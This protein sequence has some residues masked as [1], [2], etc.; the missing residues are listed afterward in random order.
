MV[1]RVLSRLNEIIVAEREV[2][3]V[4][5]LALAIYLPAIWWGLPHATH[6]LGVHGWDIDSVTGMQTLSELHNLLI[7]PKQDW[8]VAY[9]LFHYLVV[10]FF[11]GPYFV[12]L[13]LGGGMSQPTAEYPFGFAD[14]VAALKHL[15][16]IG[17][18]ITVLMASGIVVSAYLTA[19][20]VWDE[21]T[22]RFTA[23]AAALPVPMF[24]YAR[25]GNLDVPGLFWASLAI[26]FLTRSSKLGFTA[27]R[28]V[29]L[30]VF[31]SFAVAT[32][33]QAFGPLAVG[34]SML[35]ILHLWKGTPNTEGLPRWKA[36]AALFA[37]G[38]VAFAFA[39]GLVISPYRFFAHLS[40]IRRFEKTFD[41]VQRMDVL[42]PA[43]PY[44]YAVLTLDV[45][46]Q[47]VVALGPILIILGAVGLIIS[48]R[49]GTF[50]KLLVALLCGHLIL[51]IFQIR[52]MQY[53]YIL[54]PAFIFAF[55]IGRAIAVGLGQRRRAVVA[56][57]LATAIAGF[58]WAG[59]RDID[60]TYQMIYDARYEAGEWIAANS[61][62]ADKIGY[63]NA[64]SSIHLYAKTETPFVSTANPEEVKQAQAEERALWLLDD[65][66]PVEKLAGENVRF[67]LAQ[68]DFS[69]E[70]G[71]KRSRFFPES[72]YGQMN[73]GSLGYRKVA[74]FETP[75]LFTGFFLDL[76]LIGPGYIVN[77]PVEIFEK[78]A[79]R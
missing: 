44:G 74:S 57:T 7:E 69:S 61:R 77:A 35:V 58:A 68:P 46:Q 72:L 38:F 52:H 79:T 62:P 41:L 55:F 9:P 63:F 42:Q 6:P 66:S 51:V 71:W 23:I 56:A 48:W 10:S 31:S 8:Y 13:F 17:R 18:A 15:A 29:W 45:L 65:P 20:T 34:L 36:P 78:V 4:W 12:F 50:T 37:A 11:Y 3:L 40:F 33:D 1:G 14:P 43:T 64:G 22:A 47:L 19:R 76:P 16:L 5:I 39:S 49:T 54:L 26:L 60:L 27:G 2:F 75:P 32:K 59:L 73:D 24:Y 67:V 28:G 21:R 25:T 30:G 70:I 53:R